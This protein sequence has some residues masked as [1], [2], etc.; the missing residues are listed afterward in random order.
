MSED[1]NDYFHSAAEVRLKGI[2]WTAMN[3]DYIDKQAMKAAA[4]AKKKVWSLHMITFRFQSAQT[5]Q[6]TIER[7]VKVIKKGAVIRL[8]A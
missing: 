4:E 5:T 8:E 3:Q 6:L 1:E 2:V 7:D